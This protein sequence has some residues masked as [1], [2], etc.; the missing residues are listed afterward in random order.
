MSTER[1][2]IEVV[3]YWLA[4]KEGGWIAKNSVRC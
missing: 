3:N 1:E 2:L 4:I